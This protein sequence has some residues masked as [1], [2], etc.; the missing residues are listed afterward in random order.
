M[1]VDAGEHGVLHSP[2]RL[3]DP[4][5]GEVLLRFLR[6]HLPRLHP[7]EMR[8]PFVPC[9]GGSASQYL[10]PLLKGATPIDVTLRPGMV[11]GQVA[12]GIEFEP[13]GDFQHRSWWRWIANALTPFGWVAH[14]TPHFHMTGE[15]HHLSAVTLVPSCVPSVEGF[16]AAETWLGNELGQPHVSRGRRLLS[17][18]RRWEFQWGQVVLCHETRDGAAEVAI[19]W[20]TETA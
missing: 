12:G 17:R 11:P 6:T 18:S 9:E 10:S 4:H 7:P 13:A 8:S 15:E 2:S 20:E 16:A 19:S 14:P 3:I 1:Q 5:T